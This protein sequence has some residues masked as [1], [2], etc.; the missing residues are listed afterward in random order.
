MRLHM[1]SPQHQVDMRDIGILAPCFMRLGSH[2]FSRILHMRRKIQR[3][4]GACGKRRAG[5]RH[6]RCNACNQVRFHGRFPDFLFSIQMFCRITYAKV[7]LRFAGNA[8]AEKKE[9]TRV[10]SSRIWQIAGLFTA[11]AMMACTGTAKAGEGT[12]SDIPD[13]IRQTTEQVRKTWKADA[14]LAD[15]VLERDTADGPLRYDY[16]FHSS[17]DMRLYHVKRGPDGEKTEFKDFTNNPHAKGM[18]PSS[19]IDLPEAE[20]VARKHGMKGTIITAEL[21]AWSTETLQTVMVWR[22]V[23]DNDPNTDDPNDPNQKNYLVDA[24]TRTVYDAENPDMKAIGSGTEAMNAAIVEEM[25]Q[26]VQTLQNAH[27]GK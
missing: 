5:E 8:T 4:I 26:F 1:F 3:V 27:R 2:F 9:T 11:I 12:P 10:S 18:I 21:Y 7:C 15:L 6:N 25:S 22:L 14:F 23:P 13:K 16:T 17:D 19:V 24:Y 20:A